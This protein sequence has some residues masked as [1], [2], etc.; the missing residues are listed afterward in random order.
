MIS[1]FSWKGEKVV[2][3]EGGTTTWRPNKKDTRIIP[4]INAIFIS[5]YDPSGERLFFEE[6]VRP[7]LHFEG[8]W[9][10]V[11]GE[12]NIIRITFTRNMTSNSRVIDVAFEDG[13]P[14]GTFITVVQEGNT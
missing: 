12:I 10:D 4:D 1:W 14:G 5:I 6:I 9:F 8:E 11:T 3:S 2:S 7:G 13:L